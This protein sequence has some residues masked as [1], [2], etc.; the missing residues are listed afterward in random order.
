MARRFQ[1]NYFSFEAQFWSPATNVGFFFSILWQ[2]QSFHHP[3]N[4][5]Q[6][7]FG[8]Q[9]VFSHLLR[10]HCVSWNQWLFTSTNSF[11][12]DHHPSVGMWLRNCPHSASI[13]TLW[14]LRGACVREGYGAFQRCSLAGGGTSVGVGLANLSP[15][16]TSSSHFPLGV[17]SWRPGSSASCS[18]CLLPLW[19]LLLYL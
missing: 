6:G 15:R 5:G 12:G 9:S 19:T 17:C 7:H 4:S 10:E 8:A 11:L 2:V 16:P 1:D 18:G 14:S 3:A 13:W